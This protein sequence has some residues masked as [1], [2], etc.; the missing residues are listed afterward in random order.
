MSKLE[1]ALL[2]QCPRMLGQGV[3]AIH[4]QY[5]SQR[6]E[7]ASKVEAVQ[8]KALE[9]Q[10]TMQ[11]RVLDHPIM[12]I[13]RQIAKKT[14]VYEGKDPYVCPTC[15]GKYMGNILNKKPWC[16]KCGSPLVRKSKLKK[17]RLPHIKVVSKKIDY[18]TEKKKLFPG[19]YPEG[20]N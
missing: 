18:N 14:P 13:Y 2:N 7:L 8:M 20:E 17:R 5:D 10:S 19:V 12:R 11:E 16:M 15:G 3:G 6:A 9:L 1:E 4:F